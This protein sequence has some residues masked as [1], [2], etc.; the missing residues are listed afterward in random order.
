MHLLLYTVALF[1]A[2]AAIDASCYTAT[3]GGGLSI[4]SGPSTSQRRVKVVPNGGKVDRLDGTNYKGSGY[5]WYKIKYQGVTGYAAMNWLKWASSSSCSGS[6][7][8][9]S[10][11]PPR[12]SPA[13]V[14]RCPISTVTSRF[15]G[16]AY[17][18]QGRKCTNYGSNQ[19]YCGQ[20]V[21]FVRA[22]SGKVACSWKKDPSPKSA[23]QPGDVVATFQSWYQCG[24]TP[25]YGGHVGVFA[26][27]DSSGCMTIYNSNWDDNYP[28][29]HMDKADWVVHKTTIC[30][31]GSYYRVKTGGSNLE[32]SDDYIDENSTDPIGELPTSH[33]SSKGAGFIP[34]V[35]AVCGVVVVAVGVAVFLVSRKRHTLQEPLL[36]ED[37][38]EE[39][40]QAL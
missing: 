23:W 40:T 35:A 26:G 30:S 29:N 22:C 14:L 27:W 20:C 21:S 28:Y 4:R 18:G 1:C 15:K 19:N 37:D 11:P 12:P 5:T 17:D 16:N 36:D 13:G 34:V 24:F 8:G 38:L 9:G 25:S 7:G 3:A 39:D 31:F 33:I 2:I 10:T 6:S 32:D